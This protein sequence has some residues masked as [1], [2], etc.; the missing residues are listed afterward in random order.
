MV[1]QARHENFSRIVWMTFQR[2]GTTSSVSVTSSPS[3]DSFAEPQ[4]GQLAGAGITTRSRGRC[5][6]NGL[7]AGRLRW[8][9]LTVWVLAA[10]VSA[11]VSSSVA[12]AVERPAE[13]LDLQLQ[14]RDQRVGAGVHRPGLG[15]IRFGFQA[16]GALGQD[17]CMGAGEIGG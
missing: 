14:M 12:A 9:D 13:L 3:F 11:G 1:S 2:R 5:S 8:K 10:A 17:Q 7:R 6:G 16:R 15:R 4:Q